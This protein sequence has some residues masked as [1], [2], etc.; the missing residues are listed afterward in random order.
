MVA[1]LRLDHLPFAICAFKAITGLPCPTCGSTRAAA[2]LAHLDLIGGFAMNP[3]FVASAAL[4]GV[5]G[6]MD[7]VLLPRGRALALEVAPA[8]ARFLRAAAVA[9]VVANW[10]Y[11]IA[12]GR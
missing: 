2:R 11:L 3:L 12:A 8:P 5:W 4:L 9:A 1:L 10:A 6:L 7:L